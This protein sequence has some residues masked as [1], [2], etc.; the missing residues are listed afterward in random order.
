MKDTDNGQVGF[1]IIYNTCSGDKNGNLY[2]CIIKKR[3]YSICRLFYKIS[4]FGKIIIYENCI[5]YFYTMLFIL[6][7]ILNFFLL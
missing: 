6:L 5:Y 3:S 4:F 1:S 2:F 7:L